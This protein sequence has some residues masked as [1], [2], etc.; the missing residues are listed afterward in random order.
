MTDLMT[1]KVSP[2]YDSSMLT[3]MEEEYTLEPTRE[4][5]NSLADRFEKS[6]RSIIS[7]LVAMGIYQRVE[8]ATKRGEPVVRKDVIV[9]QV[10]DRLGRELPSISKMTKVDL[11]N[12]LEI[13]G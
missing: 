11:E 1:A 6:P 3:A 2:N 8:N 7:K 5:V 10:N 12:L 4:T 13:L 9:A